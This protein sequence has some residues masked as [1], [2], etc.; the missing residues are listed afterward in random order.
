[1]WTQIVSYR[2]FQAHLETQSFR[3]VQVP[4]IRGKILDRNG[5]PLAESRPEYSVSLY[6]EDLRKR[7]D[8]AYTN[9]AAGV[10]RDLAARAAN[11]DKRLARKWPPIERPPFTSTTLIKSNLA[12]QPRMRVVPNMVGNISAPR[13]K[14]LPSDPADF[15][16]HYKKRLALPYSLV[17][18]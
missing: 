11:G 7:F 14:Q 9:D 17:P 13:R 4:A 15:I 6:L 5:V 12:A 1:W 2:D 18:S 8:S 3:T 10:R 16:R